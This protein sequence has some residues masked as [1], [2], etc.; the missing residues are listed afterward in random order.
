VR[1]WVLA[2]L[3]THAEKIAMFRRMLPALRPA[4]IFLGFLYTAFLVAGVGLIMFGGYGY[5][6]VV[7]ILSAAIPCLALAVA[8]LVR[9]FGALL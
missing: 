5:F 7:L 2:K 3:T 9:R 4:L 1:L 6:G 8:E